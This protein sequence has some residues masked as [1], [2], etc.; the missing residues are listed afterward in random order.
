MRV[1]PPDLLLAI[2]LTIIAEITSWHAYFAKR[3]K[4][5]PIGGRSN[6][7]KQD[8]ANVPRAPTTEDKVGEGVD[9]P[10][11]NGISR[12][13]IDRESPTKRKVILNDGKLR[14][15][16]IENDKLEKSERERIS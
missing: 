14:E 13:G 5:V 12:V 16:E 7:D 8:H 1:P 10:K 15:A 2:L 9:K 3:A 11:G 6:K 4:D